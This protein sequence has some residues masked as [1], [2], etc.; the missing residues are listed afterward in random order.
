M[1][2]GSPNRDKKAAAPA[3][4]KMGAGSRKSFSLLAGLIGQSWPP[5]EMTNVMDCAMRCP[6]S[7]VAFARSSRRL[8]KQLAE[9]PSGRADKKCP[10]RPTGPLFP[11]H[12]D[13]PLSLRTSSRLAPGESLA[14]GLTSGGETFVWRRVA[15]PAPIALG[16]ERKRN[17]AELGS[18]GRRFVWRASSAHQQSADGVTVSLVYL[19]FFM[20][21]D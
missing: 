4:A 6:S 8:S 20:A 21:C 13:S 18:H 15:R 7:G 3:P 11:A 9:R 19:F 16:D 10:R 1:P 12:R 14:P 5:N 2:G 17:N